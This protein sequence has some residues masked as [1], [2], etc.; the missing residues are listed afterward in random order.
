VYEPGKSAEPPAS[1]AAA[2]RLASAPLICCAYTLKMG[3]GALPS[4]P[5]TGQLLPPSPL[6]TG[7]ADDDASGGA[8]GARR[9]VLL[10]F[11]IITSSGA[12]HRAWC[13]TM[14]N[15]IERKV[16]MKRMG[17]EEAAPFRAMYPQL[18][19]SMHRRTNH[20]RGPSLSWYPSP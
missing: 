3:V 7:Q 14:V 20:V 18:D 9:G 11:P 8:A 4:A 13:A 1:S 12:S 10:L 6:I 15:P 17:T 16:K 2:R 5:I 19:T